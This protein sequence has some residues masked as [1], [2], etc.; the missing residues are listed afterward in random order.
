LSGSHNQAPGFAG[1]IDLMGSR[2]DKQTHLWVVSELYYPETTSTGYFLTGIA[3]GLAS[4]YR[5]SVLC[6]QPSYIAR[7]LRAPAH[8]MRHGV[9]I[10]RCR[11]TT[12]DK[13]RLLARIVNQITIS[14]SVFLQA[15]L[16]LERGDTVLVVTNPPLL[17][18]LLLALCRLRG[19]KCA[20][21]IHDV[22]PEVLT[23]VGM[24][25]RY[26][27]AT[28]VMSFASRKLYSG[29]DWIVALG[30]D[31]KDLVKGKLNG[32][33]KNISIIT[34]WGD[35]EKIRPEAR[36]KNGLLGKL[37]LLDRFAVQYCGNIGRTHG[38]VDLLMVANELREEPDWHFLLIGWGAKKK[39]AAEQKAALSLTNL[40]ILDPLPEDELKDGLNAC[41]V[42]IIAFARGMAGISVPSRMY[43]VMASGKPL[44]AV[45]DSESELAIVVREEDIGWV[46]APGDIVALIAALREA[47][48][49]PVALRKMGERA[50]CAA[51]KKYTLECVLEKYREMIDG[52]S[53]EQDGR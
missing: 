35:T 21:I 10:W 37:D 31:M 39:W 29:V 18:Y 40:T 32:V 16:R 38:I 1:G 26:S 20:L 34:N 43:N 3:E 13:N 25:N 17:P 12:L 46:V 48:Q 11:A 44:I 2:L 8:E 7:G 47:R 53:Q 41:D 45:C 33:S 15:L 9:E 23:R 28:R 27:L 19:A 6:G 51:E 52:M 5:V 30:R 36:E 50:R 42:A 24:L 49:N 14:A 4:D 22:Y